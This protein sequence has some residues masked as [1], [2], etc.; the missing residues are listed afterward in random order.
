MISNAFAEQ[1]VERNGENVTIT[2]SRISANASDGIM[3]TA[4]QVSVLNSY[5]YSNGGDGIRILGK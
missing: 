1:D 4:R 3:I 2:N 5:I